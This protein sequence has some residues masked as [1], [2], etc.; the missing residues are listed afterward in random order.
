MNAQSAVLKQDL[1]HE[2]PVVTHGRGVFLYDTDGKEYLDGASG[3]MTA[4]IGHG[5]EEV[6]DALRDQARQVAF[7]CRTQFTSEPTEEFARR[8]VELA[9]GDLEAA[10]FVSSGSEATEFAIRAVVNHWREASRPSKVKVLSRQI[11][12]HGMT[13]G[14]LSMSGHAGRRPDY[15]SL[16]HPFQVAPPAYAYRYARDDESEE[17]YAARSAAEVEAAILAED[18]NTIPALIVE[19]IVGAAGGVLVPPVGYLPRLRRPVQSA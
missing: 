14:A 5:V 3:A 10:F 12:Y 2:Y 19:P 16:L 8:L 6:A 9:P 18:P 1:S 7:T 4:S 17:Q 13:M 15:A 11:S